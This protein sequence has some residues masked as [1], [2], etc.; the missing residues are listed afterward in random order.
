VEIGGVLAMHHKPLRILYFIIVF[1]FLFSASNVFAVGNSDLEDSSATSTGS[2]PV[3]TQTS[4][5]AYVNTVWLPFVINKSVLEPVI[6]DTTNVLS[7][8]TTNSL[9]SIS[10]DGT[11]F[12]F[13]QSSG[14]LKDLDPGEI[15]VSDPSAAAP[16]GF[17]RKVVNTSNSGGEMIVETADA[18]LEE[19]IAQGEVNFSQSLDPGDIQ[20]STLVAGTT[21]NMSPEVV[22]GM[23]FNYNLNNV[24]LYDADGNTGTTYDQ[25]KANG[26]VALNTDIN[27]SYKISWKFWKSP[28]I[29]FV[30]S[31][32]E[33]AELEIIFEA[34]YQLQKEVE[35]ARHYFSPITLWVGPVP[36]VFTPILTVY[37]GVDGTVY[38]S[39]MTRVHQAATLSYGVKYDDGWEPIGSFNNSFSFA[40][41]VVDANLSVK[42]YTG[43]SLSLLLY[44]VVGPHADLVP[45]LL[46]NAD[47]NTTP[48]WKLYG[49]LDVVAG[50]KIEVL[51]KS[52]AEYHARVIDKNW[53]IAQ[54][55][56]GPP[57]PP[58]CYFLT[59]YHTGSGSN[60]LASPSSSSGC[61]PGYYLSGEYIQLSGAAPSSG[62][63]IDSW[64]NTNNDS[65][66]SSTNSLTMPAYALSAGVN[67]TEISSTNSVTMDQIYTTDYWAIPKTT[68]R[69]GEV[70]LL[71]FDATNH[72]SYSIDVSYD[73]ETYDPYG[74]YV[75]NLSYSGWGVNVTPGEDSWYLDRGLAS[76]A[77]LGLYT[78][79]ASAAYSTGS[80]STSTTF[81][82]QG[83]PISINNLDALTSR[84]VENGDPV[85]PTAYF[86]SSDDSVYA[87]LIW[88]GSSGSHSNSFVWYRPDG[89][90]HFDYSYDFDTTDSL[91]RTWAYI[92]TSEMDPY[93]GEWWVHI[94]MDGIFVTTLY[95]TYAG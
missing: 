89:T 30:Q 23:S 90:L 31:T 57:P 68:F 16:D 60:P 38:T 27:F 55:S 77:P 88:E 70:I 43:T 20:D 7:D 2:D 93:T 22:E 73:W 34:A 92:P 54:A 83:A 19:A 32:N 95:F 79:I 78:Y 37:V 63:Q 53:L 44:G 85:D 45:Y 51:G 42:G 28:K 21:L 35:I 61:S 11:V 64:N 40:P 94:Y 39:V 5:A 52:V 74:S 82:V 33:L 69:P 9:S 1:I 41:P 81:T 87:W 86:T 58:T 80:D 17:L 6:P 18:T 24:I 76:N 8:E 72:E 71:Q 29:S 66:S 13:S 26:R 15:I 65:S 50:V 10:P 36:V 4:T 91:S 67:Y 56:G 84:G 59:L 62:W 48:W 3:D 14:E 75:N 46:L 47:I 25:V 49:G 12:T